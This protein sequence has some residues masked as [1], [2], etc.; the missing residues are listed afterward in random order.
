MF[1]LSFQP[2]SSN[3][4]IILAALSE[5]VVRSIPSGFL[6]KAF[7]TKESKVTIFCGTSMFSTSTFLFSRP[8]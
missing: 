7:T 5:L 2:L 8:I 6:D 1:S 3:C 4:F